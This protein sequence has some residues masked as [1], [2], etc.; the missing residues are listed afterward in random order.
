MISPKEENLKYRLGTYGH[1]YTRLKEVKETKNV[2]ILFVG[3]SHVYHSFDPRILE[4]EGITSFLL[5]SNSQIPSI[6]EYLLNRYLDSLNP[7][8]LAYEVCPYVMSLDGVEGS[9]EIISDETIDFKMILFV[10]GQNHL[11][12]YNTF[13]YAYLKNLLFRE[14]KYFHE[15]LITKGIST[16]LAFENH[17]IKGGYVE[18]ALPYFSHP[19]FEKVKW[20]KN[21]TNIESL[22]RVIKLVKDRKIELLLFQSPVPSQYYNSYINNDEFDQEMSELNSYINFN[23]TLKFNDSLH[24]FDYHHLNK[25]GVEVFNHQII[26]LLKER[27][28]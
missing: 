12:V 23:E 24:F 7:K 2:D 13:L 10:I 26:D 4:K 16:G 1:T 25:A 3:S 19:P 6:S 9:V 17:Y 14:K 8:M 5:S 20:I 28:N 15:P 11:T 22:K 18:R 21:P 27:I